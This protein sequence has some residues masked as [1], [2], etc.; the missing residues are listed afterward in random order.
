MYNTIPAIVSIQ[1]RKAR[2]TLF[3]TSAAAHLISNAML[4]NTIKKERMGNQYPLKLILSCKCLATVADNLSAAARPIT[5]ASREN[6]ATIKPLLIPLKTA[7]IISIRKI[8]SIAIRF[9]IPFFNR[10]EHGGKHAETQRET[11]AVLCAI[12]APLCG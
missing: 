12:S 8:I 9:Y 3:F 2:R 1:P 5:K 10:G 11:F 7:R 6:T 4:I